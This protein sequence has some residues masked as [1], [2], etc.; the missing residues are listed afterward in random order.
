MIL[1]RTTT[2]LLHTRS[3]QDQFYLDGQSGDKLYINVEGKPVDAEGK[4]IEGEIVTKFVY[5]IDE[6][7]KAFNY[8]HRPFLENK[9]GQ[10][11]IVQTYP[12]W[13]A[14]AGTMNIVTFYPFFKHPRDEKYNNPPTV[15]VND[16][17]DAY[18]RKVFKTD[19]EAQI[20]YNELLSLAPF[21]R[22][23]LIAFGYV[24][25]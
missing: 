10:V 19:E 4:V 15:L 8:Q 17:D 18:A 5:T 7:C 16:G 25:E 22:D 20:A 14:M 2:G 12:G 23:E 11:A 21:T 24:M 13:S 1:Y 6:Y 9:R 3:P